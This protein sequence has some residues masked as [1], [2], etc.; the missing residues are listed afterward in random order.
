MRDLANSVV[1]I[2]NPLHSF[3]DEVLSIDLSGVP[4]PEGQTSACEPECT[5][6]LFVENLGRVNFG[7][8]HEFHQRKGL[9]EG[10]VNLDGVPLKNWEI[11]SL[12]FKS[13]WVSR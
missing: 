1:A 11:I 2:S 7:L 4:I 12:E 13:A 9:W 3:S 10:P 8:P 6:D 5:L